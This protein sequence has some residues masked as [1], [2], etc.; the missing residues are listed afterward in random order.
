MSI[1][2]TP[3]TPIIIVDDRDDNI[4]YKGR[5]NQDDDSSKILFGGTG[6]YGVDVGANA[7]FTFVGSYIAVYAQVDPDEL[8]ALDISLDDGTQKGS[9]NSSTFSGEV[10]CG[11]RKG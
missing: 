4:V 1:Q 7:S 5:W 2:G 10:H 6:T 8:S 11:G 3:S 9:F